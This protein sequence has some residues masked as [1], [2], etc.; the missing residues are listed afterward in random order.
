MT[1][2]EIRTWFV[3]ESG[4]YDL[5]TD[6]TSYAD[7]GADKYIN[8]AIRM[9]DRMQDT[10]FMLGHNWQQVVADQYHV[11]FSKPYWWCR[12]IKKVFATKVSDTSRTE[13]EK[14]DLT[15]I[16]ELH[17]QWLAGDGDTG[18]PLYYAPGVFRLAPEP[19]QVIGDIDVPANY[20]DYIGES[21]WDYNG[22]LFT[23][24]CDETYAIE[25]WGH[26]YT[27]SLS[28]DTDINWWT[29]NHP[30]LVV[31]ASQLVLEKMMRNTEGVKD[32][33]AAIKMELQGIDFDLVEEDIAAITC[34]GG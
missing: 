26:F 24:A 19:D 32:W 33:T 28:A 6:T 22:V 12:A 10:P 11:V 7:N 4:R 16:K 13:L 34:L 17:F 27:N 1:L 18:T 8:S 15:F 3:Q 30:E 23:P 21:S 2:L 9:L 14:K 20:L 31:M 25:V 29:S 5:V